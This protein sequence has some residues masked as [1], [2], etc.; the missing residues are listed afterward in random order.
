MALEVGRA[1]VSASSDAEILHELRRIADA[2]ETLAGT[3][4]RS[5]TYIGEAGP[6]EFHRVDPSGLS[7]ESAPQLI[8]NEVWQAL[9]EAAGYA[10]RRLSKR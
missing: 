5:A 4:K 2:L 10:A 8:E 6:M 9:N 3:R 1:H 7:T